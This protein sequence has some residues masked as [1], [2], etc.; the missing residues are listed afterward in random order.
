MYI[1]RPEIAPVLMRT[2]ALRLSESKPIGEVFMRFKSFSL[3]F[4]VSFLIC[5]G[6]VSAQSQRPIYVGL[7]T[8][9]TAN[10]PIL[11][12]SDGGY[13][14]KYGLDVKS[15]VMTGSSVALSSMIAGEVTMIN[16]AVSGLINSYLAGADAT[17]VAGLVN[18]PPTI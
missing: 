3:V 8:I 2:T 13:F 15:I 17:M 11:A 18:S 7:V 9:T 5:I 16:V 4:V 10:A 14:K 1:F 12:V 6:S